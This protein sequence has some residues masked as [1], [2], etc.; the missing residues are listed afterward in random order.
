MNVNEALNIADS[1]DRTKDDPLAILAEEVRRLRNLFPKRPE[2]GTLA[3]DLFYSH[4]DWT[5]PW[6]FGHGYSLR[7]GLMMLKRDM[8]REF[9]STVA[10]DFHERLSTA[11][12]LV[13]DNEQYRRE[14][15]WHVESGIPYTRDE[16]E[17]TNGRLI[18][19]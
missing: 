14:M 19:K 10:Q 2:K 6:R 17:I 1:G 15:K 7:M 18:K 8:L 12:F 9:S 11:F 4:G 16:I 3:V 13:G 5:E